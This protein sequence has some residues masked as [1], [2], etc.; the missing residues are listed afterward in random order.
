MATKL[1]KT[2]IIKTCLKLLSRKRGQKFLQLEAAEY[3]ELGL[4]ALLWGDSFLG[5]YFELFLAG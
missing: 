4:P 1:S 5:W 2:A 3:Q